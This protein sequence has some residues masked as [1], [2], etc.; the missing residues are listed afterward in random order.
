MVSLHAHKYALGPG[1][2]LEQSDPAKSFWA[3]QNWSLLLPRCCSEVFW[4]KFYLWVYMG[5]K[6]EE[7]LSSWNVLTEGI[8]TVSVILQGIAAISY[9][10]NLESAVKFQQSIL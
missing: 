3:L 2:S 6:R 7:N 4:L 5:I 9:S 1:F 8:T 10:E